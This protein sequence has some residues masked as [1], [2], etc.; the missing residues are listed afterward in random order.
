M[1]KITQNHR[2]QVQKWFVPCTYSLLLYNSI[3]KYFKSTREDKNMTRALPCWRRGG[4]LNNWPQ[5]EAVSE[6]WEAGGEKRWGATEGKEEKSVQ[7]RREQRRESRVKR[8][9][10]G[11]RKAEKKAGREQTAGLAPRRAGTLAFVQALVCVG[12]VMIDA[13]LSHHA[14]DV[15]WNVRSLMRSPVLHT[16]IH[17]L[18]HSQPIESLLNV[19]RTSKLEDLLCVCAS[20]S[21]SLSFRPS[22]HLVR[23]CCHSLPGLYWSSYFLFIFNQ[24]AGKLCC[25]IDESLREAHSLAPTEP[26]LIHI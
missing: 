8:G 3:Q 24:K 11:K 22:L 4:L 13:R 20:S 2:I 26:A 17:T 18:P 19:R 16:H 9:R 10:R 15:T 23:L 14:A 7:G 1:C 12:R 5:R 6:E 21:L 25:L